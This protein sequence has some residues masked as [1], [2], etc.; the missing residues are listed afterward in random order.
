M[1]GDYWREQGAGFARFYERS[2]A[3]S[4]ARIVGGFLEARTR[5]LD[6][7]GPWGA[8]H[9]LLDLGCGSGVHMKRA[10]ELCRHVAGIDLSPEMVALARAAMA[11]VP[12]ERWS[13]QQGDAAALPFPDGHFDGILSMGLFDYVPS[14]PAV[15]G[16]CRRVLVPH[17]L[18]V[19]TLP[20]SPSPFAVLRSAPGNLVKRLVFGLPPVD[21]VRS[22]EALLR[23]LALA[24][25]APERVESVWTAMWMVR[26]RALR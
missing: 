6:E 8:A 18:L 21:N 14:V 11:G 3:F 25:F 24:G 19:F 7:M 23:E 9:R 15:L 17:G 12:A 20:R 26:A 2:R 4:P 22:R 13:V 5:L 1:P 16:E 10:A